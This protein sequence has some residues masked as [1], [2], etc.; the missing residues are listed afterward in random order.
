MLEYLVRNPGARTLELGELVL[1][2]FLSVAGDALPSTLGS[3][4]SVLLELAVDTSQ[5][6]TL[7]GQVSLAS[8]DPDANENPFVFNLT[9]R[10]GDTPANALYV[11]P[12]IDLAD[13]TITPNQQNVPIYSA[14][15]LVPEG[16]AD[17]TINSLTLNTDDIPALRDVISLTLLID[18]GT[19]GIQDNR[20]VVLSTIDN[21]STDGTITFEFEERTLQ[22]N[23]PFWILVTVDF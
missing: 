18:G 3:F 13:T 21:P 23:L 9:I 4:D 11:L 14:Y 15:L 7:A 20:D 19:R 12:G 6:G 2:S 17:V 8:N 22:P 5:A 1:P 10:V 16:S